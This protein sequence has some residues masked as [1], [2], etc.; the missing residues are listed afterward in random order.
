[1][2]FLNQN[3]GLKRAWL[4]AWFVGAG[5]LASMALA[6]GAS[7]IPAFARKYGTSCTTCHTIYPK[8]TPFGEAF[9][10]NGF[11]FPGID[12]DYVKAEPVKLG[13]D[14]YKKLFPNAVWPGSLPP[15]VP[16][17]LGFNGQAVM[18]PQKSAG[19]AQADNGALVSMND[20]IAE[21]HVWMGGSYD[22]TTTFFGE[23]T[24]GHGSAEVEHALVV[25]SDIAGPAHA[26][27]LAV[28]KA[29]AQLSSFG[30]HSSYLSDMSA[31]LVAMAPLFGSADDGFT[32]HDPHT[33]VEASGVLAGRIDYAAGVKAGSSA[34]VHA[35]QDI[36]AHIGTKFGGMRLDGE[37][38]APPADPL[39]PWA[40]QA[41]TVDAFAYRAVTHF[42]LTGTDS[43]T[44][45]VED[46]SVS[47]GGSVRLQWNSLELTS[48]AMLE[49]HDHLVADG[50]G[51]KLMTQYNELS[52]IVYPWLVPA[53]RVE[54]IKV[55]PD[56]S[57]DLTDL[58]IMP[59]IAALVRPN[60]KL[61]LSAQIEQ[62]KGSPVGG[63]G[64]A[65][66][67]AMPTT[68]DGKVDAEIESI[69]LTMATAF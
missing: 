51:A 22:D 31:L 46:K 15:S 30:S 57:G 59:G 36:Y 24:F 53:L 4:V 14:E 68:P 45:D 19:A 67:A 26:L 66:G 39:K 48:G 61:V 1:M 18:H 6:P 32:P 27:N 29:S 47:M 54:Y 2:D 28:G 16:I 9:R 40:E 38:A 13:Q 37:G 50:K 44:L 5:T 11:R 20:L 63:W 58:R 43:A 33:G 35:S 65:G 3:R 8:L 21:G 12:S 55:S 56:G 10:R 23:L 7:A 42:G 41:V 52:Y 69:G 62:A 64:P 17:A 25:F 34:N 60:L 49:T